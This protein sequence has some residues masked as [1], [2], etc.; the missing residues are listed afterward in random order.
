MIIDA[1]DHSFVTA[2]GTRG[3][4]PIYD[5]VLVYIVYNITYNKYSNRKGRKVLLKLKLVSEYL[6]DV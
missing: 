6:R 2:T 5:I 4:Y 1:G 3:V